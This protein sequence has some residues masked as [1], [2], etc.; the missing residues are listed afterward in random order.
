M[1]TDGTCT[2]LDGCEIAL[3]QK[4]FDAPAG[5][6]PSWQTLVGL[7]ARADVQLDYGSWDELCQKAEEEIQ[8]EVS[9]EKA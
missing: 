3:R 5:I 6:S 8:K 1:E 2:G 7:A 9:R 4:M